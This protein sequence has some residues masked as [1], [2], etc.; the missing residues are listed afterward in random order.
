MISRTG[1]FSVRAALTEV[2]YTTQDQPERERVF[3]LIWRINERL[4]RADRQRL[5]RP[6]WA[7]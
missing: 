2:F 7:A 3:G 6:G 5:S 1:L 4:L